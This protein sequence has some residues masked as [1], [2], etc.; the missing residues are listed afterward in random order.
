M[1]DVVIRPY[2]GSDEADLL[3]VWNAAL[4]HDPINEATWRTRVLLDAN[5]AADGVLVAERAG[6][7][8]GFVLSIARQVPL[9]L[10]GLEPEVAWITA[11]GVLPDCRR[12]GIGRQL[13]DTALTR[14]RALGRKRVLLS[15]YTPNYFTPGV[16]LAAYPE[17]IA[18]LAAAGWETFSKPVSM[19]VEL[20]GFQVPPE[21]VA[22][23]EAL[24][25]EGIVVRPL[26]AAD[27]PALLPF[28]VQHFGWD[29]FR[30]AQEVLTELLGRGADDICF[31]VALQGEQIVGYCQQRRERFGPFGVA[32]QMRGKGVGRI[33]LF[34]CLASALARNFHCAWF[35]WTSD[36]NARLYSLAGFRQ[37]RRFA[38]LK[39]ML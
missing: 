36:E 18:F 35:L 20:T 8:C 4:T 10:Q 23:Q 27:V 3:R 34:R 11:F 17:A 31:F 37:V 19:R 24:Q 16:D 6:R 32:K 30:H 5:F 9:F 29:W 21:I 14:L 39:K 13:F 28:I 38:V 7:L 2:R 22:K 25:A 1:S 15:P 26:Q 33:L 12:Q